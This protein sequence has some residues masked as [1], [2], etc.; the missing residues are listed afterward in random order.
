MEVPML[1]S[2]VFTLLF[3]LS[4]T[5]FAAVDEKQF[6]ISSVEVTEIGPIESGFISDHSN[7][8]VIAGI[9]EV[10]GVVDALIALGKKVYPIVEAGKPVLSTDLPVTHVLPKLTNEMSDYDLT[11]GLM[12][13]WKLP[14]SRSYKVV[15]KNLYGFEVISFTYT[16]YFQY[17]GSYEGAGKYLTGVHVSATDLYV[18]WGFDFSANTEVLSIANLGTLS[19]PVASLSLRLNWVVKT[20]LVEN[21]SSRIYHLTG[22]GQLK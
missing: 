13:N 4:L 14:K 5:S 8:N 2:L 18:S 17:G 21:R 7:K 22:D 19:N 11:L 6:T 20:V 16:I 15:Y 12:E 10:I 1:Q 9:G 3:S